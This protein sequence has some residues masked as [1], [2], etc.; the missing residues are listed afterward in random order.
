MRTLVSALLTVTILAPASDAALR[1]HAQGGSGTAA[2][3]RDADVRHS[4]ANLTNKERLTARLPAL[5]VNARLMEAAQLQA[6]Q[7]ARAR[8]LAHDLPKAPLPR[9]LDRVAA[10]KYVWSRI[11][12]NIASGQ[13]TAAA[14]MAEWM[15]S[16][17][18]RTNIMNP[19]FTDVGAGVARDDGGVPYY[20]QVFGAPR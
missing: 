7:M 18:H 8:T 19:A 12:E 17:G 13:L 14:T 9:L 6:A 3:P 11:A 1:P 15:A 20:V 2:P 10:V 5:R 16:K 4:V